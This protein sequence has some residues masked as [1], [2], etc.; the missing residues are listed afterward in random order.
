MS[1]SDGEDDDEV[2]YRNPP[3]RARFP[4]GQSGNPRGRPKGRKKEPPYEAVL[5]QMVTIKEDGSERR[6]AADQAFLLQVAK[7]GLDGDGAAARLAMRAIEEARAVR[8]TSSET[9]I[10]TSSGSL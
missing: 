7:R 1:R 8:A 4:K 6:V 9:R 5:G 10:D 2:G 3:V